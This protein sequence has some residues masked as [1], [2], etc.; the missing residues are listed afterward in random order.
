MRNLCS[1]EAE[2][3][4][5]AENS[6]F[7]VES[8]YMKDLSVL[9]QSLMYLNVNELRDL[10]IKLSL[11]DKGNKIAIILRILHFFETGQ[12]L[13]LPQFPEKSCSRRGVSYPLGEHEIM[14]KGAYRNDLK[15]RLF[16][17]LLIGKHFHFTAFGIDWLNE[18]WMEGNP[19][20]Y[21]EFAMMW[22]DEYQKRK[23]WPV[24]PKEEWA[25]I[26]F[27]QKHLRDFPDATKESINSAWE[28]ERQKHKT[29][30]YS[31]LLNP[32]YIGG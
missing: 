3:F 9:K 12:K 22:Q 25:Y 24:A 11:I 4:Q 27:M 15:T 32:E 29:H 6:H 19:P 23:K 8:A 28:F 20:T 31:V 7:Q 10:A 26:R 30:V 1:F 16:F 13:I 5:A 21:R 18:R 17:K 14:L 2:S